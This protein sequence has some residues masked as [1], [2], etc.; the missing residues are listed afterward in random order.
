VENKNVTEQVEI[1]VEAVRRLIESGD[2]DRKCTQKKLSLPI[3]ARLSKKMAANI[4]FSPIKVHNDIICDGH[5]RYVASKLTGKPVNES[6]N[7]LTSATSIADWFSVEIVNEDWD[8]V[9]EI[10]NFNQI[11][12]DFNGLT[13][14]RVIEIVN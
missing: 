12:A 11:D 6:P 1:S 13:V 14:E 8:S 9:E 3:I 10:A 4:K 7:L 5:H 2:L